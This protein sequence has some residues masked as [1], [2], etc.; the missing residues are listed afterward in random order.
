M[1]TIFNLQWLR[2]KREPALPIIFLV[3]T[4]LFVLFVAGTGGEQTVTVQTFSDNLSEPQMEEWLDRLNETDTFIFEIQDKETIEEQIQ[5]SQISFAL[6]LD[7][8][9]YRFIVGQD[10]QFLMAVNQHVEKVYRTNLRINEVNAQF[11]DSE[12][13]QQDF[14]GIESRTLAGGVSNSQESYANVIVGMTLYFSI[15]TI[16]FGLM[17]IAEEKRTGTWDR[18]ISTPLKKSEIYVGQLLHY[19]FIGLLQIGIAFFIFHQFFNYNFGSQ[20]LA[21]LV[22]V[23]VFVFAVVSLGMLIISLIK[24]PQQLQAVIPIVAT[25]IAMLGGAFWPLEIVNNNILLILG[26]MTP[27]Y[28]GMGALK[29]AILYN[30]GIAEILEPLSILLLMGVLFMGIGLNLMEGKNKKSR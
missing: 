7:E 1:L 21:I 5:M 30:R 15:Y 19:F 2:L 18:L 4:L 13:V 17:N 3:M 12:V 14:I 29:G 11:P 16:L 28:Y 10:S 24:S 27:I 23:M 20:Y 8:N 22:S 6:E 25:G 26:R 9:N